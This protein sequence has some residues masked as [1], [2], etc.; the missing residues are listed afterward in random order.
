MKTLIKYEIKNIFMY[1]VVMG[2]LTLVPTYWRFNLRN[3][4]MYFS[5]FSYA[6]IMPI[7]LNFMIAIMVFGLVALQ[8][9][10]IKG[11]NTSGILR[12]LPI[13][14]ANLIKLKIGVGVMSITIVN[15]I[16]FLYIAAFRIRYSDFIEIVNTSFATKEYVAGLN[17]WLTILGLMVCFNLVYILFYLYLI[18]FQYII[19]NSVVATSVGVIMLGVPAYLITGLSCTLAILGN[20]I[21]MFNQAN[22]I[23]HNIIRSNQANSIIMYYLTLKPWIPT[24]FR[25]REWTYYWVTTDMHIVTQPDTNIWGHLLVIVATLIFL[26]C[27]INYVQ[28]KYGMNTEGEQ[29]VNKAFKVLFLLGVVVCGFL[30]GPILSGVSGIYSGVVSG[31]IGLVCALFMYVFCKKFIVD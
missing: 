23:V 19:K 26:G 7:E 5:Q 14:Q 3:I 16:N 1:V 18:I 2:L 9:K 22:G 10:D 24:Q 31:A 11:N 6:Y 15:F 25:D 12:V 4:G 28:N 21:V 30:I 17:S 29:F 8:F 20:N 27:V 13:T